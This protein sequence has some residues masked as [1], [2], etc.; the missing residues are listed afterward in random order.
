MR[1]YLYYLH[2]TACIHQAVTCITA[3]SLEV[4]AL[5]GSRMIASYWNWTG[6]SASLQ[7]MPML[8]LQAIG[9]FFTHISRLRNLIR[10]GNTTSYC[11][12]NI[13][14]DTT[15]VKHRIT[16]YQTSTSSASVS[17]TMWWTNEYVYTGVAID[18][19]ISWSMPCYMIFPLYSVCSN[20]CQ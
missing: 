7:P 8:N 16:K 6:T 14:H 11:L 19:T 1:C 13:R 10:F 15:N 9:S 4:T 17:R 3:N 12:M 18:W 20:N 5:S 2:I